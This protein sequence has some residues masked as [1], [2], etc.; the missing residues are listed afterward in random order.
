MD[1]GF[2]ITEGAVETFNMVLITKENRKISMGHVYLPRKGEKNGK[3][4]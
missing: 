1:Y 4:T 3:K 2:S